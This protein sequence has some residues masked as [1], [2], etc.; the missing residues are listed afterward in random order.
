MG[1]NKFESIKILKFVMKILRIIHNINLDDGTHIRIVWSCS[2]TV[3][4]YKVSIFHKNFGNC[5]ISCQNFN[6][7]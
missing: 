7:V 5:K 2:N 3:K 4:T 6:R 1:I